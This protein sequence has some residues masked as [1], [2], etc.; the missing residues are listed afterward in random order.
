MMEKYGYAV[1]TLNDA[2]FSMISE[3]DNQVLD[4]FI[5]YLKKILLITRHALDTGDQIEDLQGE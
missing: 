1:E 4:C 5:K 2:V 3:K